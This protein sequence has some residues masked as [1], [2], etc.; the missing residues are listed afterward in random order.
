LIDEVETCLEM[1]QPFWLVVNPHMLTYRRGNAVIDPIT[2]ESF[3][4]Q[5]PFIMRTRWNTVIVDEAHS[6]GLPNTS[7]QTARALH[8]LMA[9][10]R[11][12]MTGTPM[13]GKPERLWGIFHWLEPSKFTSRYRWR[14]KWIETES[15]QN[16]DGRRYTL[17][18]GIKSGMEEQFYKE[19][20][21]LML[22]RRKSEVYKEM[23][24]KN[25]IPVWVT[26]SDK[27]REQYSR[28]ENEAEALLAQ[29]EEDEGKV[30]SP[31]VL[32]TYAWLKQFSFGVC[33]I[34]ERGY[35]WSERLEI[36][37]M[38]YG[39][40]ATVESPKLDALME[41]LS[42]LGVGEGLTGDE[43]PQVVVFSQFAH[44]VDTV[45]AHLESKGIITAKITGKTADREYRA[46]VQKDFQGGE[47]LEVV[48]MTTTAGGVAINLD[49]ADTVVFL[50]ETWNPDDQLQAEDR[51][52]R[53][54][55]IHNVTVYT[56]RT[57]NSVDQEVLTAVN[58]KRDINEVLLD[59]Y[60][61]KY[62]TG[63]EFE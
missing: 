26:M 10:K 37:E 40:K 54:S 63:E 20:A 58:T 9:R 22:R 44:V 53:A 25:Y 1:D 14:D 43:R 32:T 61:R 60:R 18:G 57:K 8:A 38:K 34:Y 50:D 23:P 4:T 31:N 30:S 7:S 17:V 19:H 29:R 52:H 15:R 27:Q 56:I 21:H 6:N 41:L 42:E 12:A 2:G 16:S 3:D 13:G 33:E 51:C 48:V 36:N 5:F 47:N 28:M 59:R 39:A 45:H 49:R 24:E 62:Q 46:N 35:K 55:R 11:I